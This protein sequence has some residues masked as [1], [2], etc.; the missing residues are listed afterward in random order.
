MKLWSRVFFLGGLTGKLLRM[1]QLWSKHEK[2]LLKT[3][4]L[5]N[6]KSDPYC[7]LLTLINNNVSVLGHQL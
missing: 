3:I 5:Y 7:K 4:E 2:H 6:R 1:I